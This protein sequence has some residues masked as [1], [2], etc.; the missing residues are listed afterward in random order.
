MKNLKIVIFT[1]SMVLASVAI[2]SQEKWS[3]E[4]RPNI[5]FPTEDFVDTNI[6]VG[7]G[8]EVAFGY[9]FME[10]LGAY[11]GWGYN[12][13]N[14]KDSDVDFDETGYTFGL[15]FIHPIGSSENLSLLFRAGGIYNHIELEDNDGNLIDDSG[16]GFG[17]EVGAGLNYNIGGNWNLRPQI[18]YRTLSRD[19]NIEETTFNVDV[20]Y[21]AVGLG[22]AVTF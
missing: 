4:F 7:Y 19:L 6:K 16:H 14:I 20:N 13:F 3:V 17:W 9:Q 11:A 12:N 22:I 18:G 21:I 15:Q 5:N 2:F 1:L 8:F 10:H